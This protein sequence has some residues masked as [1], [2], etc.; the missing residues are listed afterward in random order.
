ML[1]VQILERWN[2]GKVWCL[3][4]SLGL[5]LSMFI[6]DFTLCKL[7][8]IRCKQEIFQAPQNVVN[9]FKEFQVCWG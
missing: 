4:H 2:V 8:K 6:P 7:C 3:V 1:N 5:D 9:N